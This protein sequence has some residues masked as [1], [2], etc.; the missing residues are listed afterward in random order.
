[1]KFKWRETTGYKERQY[2][3]VEIKYIG[4]K[5]KFEFYV[6]GT[7]V[8]GCVGSTLAEAKSSVV[9]NYHYFV[10]QK[11]YSS[12]SMVDYDTEDYM[13]KDELL[14][15]LVDKEAFAIENH[16]GIVGCRH[17]KSIERVLDYNQNFKYNTY[18]ANGYALQYRA[19]TYLLSLFN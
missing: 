14:S 2:G 3:L 19:L 17:Q 9:E 1:M 8:G 5:G 13:A 4:I 11:G 7:K 6:R 12:E 16:R 10:S 18:D 15:K